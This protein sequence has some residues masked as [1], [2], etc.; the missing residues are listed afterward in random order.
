MYLT[1]ASAPF[2]LHIIIEFP[3]AIAFAYKPSGTLPVMQSGA[4]AIIRQYALLLMSSNFIA[5]CLALQDNQLPGLNA[6][7]Q[8]VAASLAVYHLGPAVRA[9]GRVRRRD[10][11]QS[12]FANSWLHVSVHM[13]SATALLGRAAAQAKV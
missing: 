5:G 6:V 7:S 8:G 12:F 1:W 2:L 11:G 10:E 9:I 13:L 3:A 4:H